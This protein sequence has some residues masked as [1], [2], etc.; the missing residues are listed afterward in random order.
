M[1]DNL[2]DREVK[3]EAQEALIDLLFQLAD[4]DLLVAFHGSEW[5]GLA[6]HVEEDVA[7]SSLAQDEMGHAAMYFGLLEDLGVGSRD[8]LA[9]LRPPASR[10]NAIVVE[11]KNGPGTYLEN[12]HYDW[13]FTIARAYCYDVMEGL[14]LE[15]LQ[16]SSYPPLREVAQK[17]Q[18]EEK[19]HRMHHEIWIRRM[20]LD[21]EAK[22]RLQTAFNQVAEDAGDLGYTG[23]YTKE[24]EATGILPD[25][26][27]L[28]EAWQAQITEFLLAEGLT[29]P[30]VTESRGGRIG[31]HTK[32]LEDALNTLS[33]VYRSDPSARW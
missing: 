4:D 16:T 27:S 17:I 9:H 18:G 24:L 2:R 29:W 20:A 32:D 21:P 8:D 15:R 31:E 6:P 7:L 13:A 11:L 23:L 3:A 26:S 30:G 22:S 19:Y 10:R 1:V 14:R 5:L 33:E 12:P 25:A 28:T